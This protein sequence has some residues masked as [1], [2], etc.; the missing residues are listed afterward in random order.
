MK[1]IYTIQILP[2]TV[3]T[4]IPTGGEIQFQ[5]KKIITEQK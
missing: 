3:H 4:A 5:D 2:Q 1:K